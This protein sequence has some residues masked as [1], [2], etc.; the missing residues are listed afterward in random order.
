MTVQEIRPLNSSVQKLPWLSRAHSA[1]VELKPEY[2][3]VKETPN[4]PTLRLNTSVLDDALSKFI[5]TYFVVFLKVASAI[6][7]VV[8]QSIKELDIGKAARALQW[9][10]M[11]QFGNEI[12]RHH[13]E[14]IEIKPGETLMP[15]ADNINQNGRLGASPHVDQTK[16][17]IIRSLGY[18]PTVNIARN[19]K[20]TIWNLAESPYNNYS[21]DELFDVVYIK[22]DLLPYIENVTPD[23]DESERTTFYF[24]D[25]LV[26]HSTNEIVY[27][28]HIAPEDLH[29]KK[30]FRW[31]H[32][33]HLEP[34]VPGSKIYPPFAFYKNHKTIGPNIICRRQEFIEGCEWNKEHLT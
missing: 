24:I 32:S 23:K 31:V 15:V 29:S 7:E 18:S 20:L 6:R 26:A 8:G 1:E 9:T 3:I 14:L 10:T 11:L 25:G 28:S 4:Y 33:G 17:K 27:S 19:N 21:N 34:F 5:D 13:P 16:R 12:R 2:L 30:V 22:S